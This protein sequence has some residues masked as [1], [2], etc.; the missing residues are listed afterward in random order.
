MMR[1]GSTEI[2]LL[3]ERQAQPMMEPLLLIIGLLMRS[4]S[5]MITELITAQLRLKLLLHLA[6]GK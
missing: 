5:L 3:K 6:T 2:P 1:P 4:N